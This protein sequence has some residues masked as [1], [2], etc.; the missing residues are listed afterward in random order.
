M[1]ATYTRWIHYGESVEAGVTEHGDQ[2]DGEDHA[3]GIHLGEYEYDADSE[4]HELIG[5]LYTAA[6]EDG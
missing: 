2:V 6:E 5:E 3:D 4:V 1:S